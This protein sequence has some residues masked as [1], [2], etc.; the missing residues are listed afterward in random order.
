MEPLSASE[1][2]KSKFRKP[3][4]NSGFAFLAA[5]LCLVVY[6]LACV[7]SP[8]SF[9]RDGRYLVFWNDFDHYRTLCVH[10]LMTRKT[11][12]I[13]KMCSPE[14]ES[15]TSGPC[16]SP[17]GKWIAYAAMEKTWDKTTQPS[18][19]KKSLSTNH[20][21][22]SE[23]ELHRTNLPY[24]GMPGLIQKALDSPPD[25]K[26]EL[27]KFNVILVSRDGKS[28]KQLFSAIM[29][30]IFK[31]DDKLI[32]FSHIHWSPDGISIYARA[33]SSWIRVDVLTGKGEV[34]AVTPGDADLSPDGKKFAVVVE[35]GDVGVW[36]ISSDTWTY[37]RDVCQKP[38]ES[39]Q[40][41][42]RFSPDGKHLVAPGLFIQKERSHPI[43]VLNLE[44][45]KKNII[46]LILPPSLFSVPKEYM[47]DCMQWISETKFRALI[48]LMNKDPGL[49]VAVLEYDLINGRTIV[50]QQFPT[51]QPAYSVAGYDKDTW[52]AKTLYGGG[53]PNEPQFIYQIHHNG[54]IYTL[55]GI[56]L[57]FQAFPTATQPSRRDLPIP[58][59]FWPTLAAASFSKDG[60]YLALAVK[61]GW[62]V[63][64]PYFDLNRAKFVIALHDL[65]TRRTRILTSKEKALPI[66]PIW[67]ADGKSIV[68][69]YFGNDPKVFPTT[70]R[71][72][73]PSP[74]ELQQE[75]SRTKSNLPLPLTT[76]ANEM[77]RDSLERVD[78]LSN[79]NLRFVE[80]PIDGRPE[81][82]IDESPLWLRS[83]P[84]LISTLVSS[85]QAN[86]TVGKAKCVHVGLLWSLQNFKNLEALFPPETKIANNPDIPF[87][88]AVWPDQTLTLYDQ[89]RQ[90]WQ[91]WT[92]ALE[93]M[94]IMGWPVFNP[95]G[96]K[97]AIPTT[98][99]E[100]P[101][102]VVDVKSGSMKKISLM[103]PSS[104]PSTPTKTG[105]NKPFKASAY[106]L[107]W[108]S[109]AKLKVLVTNDGMDC[110]AVDTDLNGTV[111]GK[112]DL[113]RAEALAVHDENLWAAQLRTG[114][115]GVPSFR[116]YKG[117]ETY[118]IDG[119]KLLQQAFPETQFEQLWPIIPTAVT[120]P[121]GQR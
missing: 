113:G 22:T 30:C 6:I 40:P 121:A 34:L 8:M 4:L 116:V 21:P 107:N 52:V 119:Q 19:Q 10:D 57:F 62:D 84:K 43:T 105:L 28:E 99:E 59:L 117:K 14:H 98:D 61:A 33:P 80:L 45:H 74:Q 89:N 3:L 39:T 46:N 25:G 100:N 83:D 88:A 96:S 77:I 37:F 85:L 111:L 109:P 51:S 94:Q 78:W 41:W 76:I 118:I 66:F 70:Q 24:V 48:S 97:V 47:T 5:I 9:S 1:E 18:T 16:F 104:Q 91:M 102:F 114:I 38:G 103:V 65:Q 106:G 26:K 92:P 55:N 112:T 50:V 95:D 73:L 81:K 72:E 44:T 23:T 68:Y 2:K 69:G 7:D 31:D 86:P 49:G 29:P 90:N 42:I 17:D 53:K 115:E 75:I 36:D 101:V 12:I 79:C 56:S 110:Y 87:L 58:G 35:N 71:T 93:P 60:R 13:K 11:K 20:R 54:T 27:A 120:Q 32:A 108:L 67:S 64:Q 82:K 15:L 63:N